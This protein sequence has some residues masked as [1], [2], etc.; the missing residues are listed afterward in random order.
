MI[1]IDSIVGGYA[2]NQSI[3]EIET[4]DLRP[5]FRLARSACW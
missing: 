3:L 5:A 4:G 1:G 2:P